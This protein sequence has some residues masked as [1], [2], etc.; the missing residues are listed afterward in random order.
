MENSHTSNKNTLTQK[1]S[2]IFYLNFFFFNSNVRQAGQRRLF[3]GN[4]WLSF[5][6]NFRIIF[7]S[8]YII[9]I[10]TVFI[11]LL[12]Q[13]GL[14]NLFVFSRYLVF[15]ITSCLQTMIFLKKCWEIVTFQIKIG[16]F[17]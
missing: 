8:H 4:C 12:F 3:S 15:L 6:F 14:I 5:C 16:Q 2:V 7:L 11:G 9:S 13:S 1:N 17:F 10:N